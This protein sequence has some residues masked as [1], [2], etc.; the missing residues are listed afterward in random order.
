MK[1]LRLGRPSPALLV[2]VLA[3]VA[4]LTGT[5]L[6]GGPGAVASKLTKSKVKT[7]SQKQ[8]NKVLKQEAP[9]LEVGS[10]VA[11]TQLE[12][13]RSSS[14]TVNPGQTD[15]A[16]ATCPSGKFVTGGGG[17]GADVTSLETLADHPSTGN[18]NQLGYTAWEYRVHNSGGA[19]HTINAYAICAN[20]KAATGQNAT[21]SN[22]TVGQTVP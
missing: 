15:S 5:A 6:A 1:T 10:A 2:A 9:N 16:I 12:Y 22:Y 17:A 18:P 19:P 14:T 11:L 3:L 21:P 8:A 7:I 20:L 4:G 13:V